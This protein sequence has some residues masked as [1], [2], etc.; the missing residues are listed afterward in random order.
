MLAA[1]LPYF[2]LHSPVR[3]VPGVSS[4]AVD[5]AIADVLAAAGSP[6]SLCCCWRRP[7]VVEVLCVLVLSTF[8]GPPAV[9]SVLL[10]F[11]SLP[12]LL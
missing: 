10:M 1:L 4:A 9:F 3:D 7:S 6:N 2:C 5:P 11:A 8:Y 12:L